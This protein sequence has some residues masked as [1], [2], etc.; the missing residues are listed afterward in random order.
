MNYYSNTPQA[1]GFTPQQTRAAFNQQLA[2]AQASAD[3]RYNMKP[4][5]RAGWSRGGAQNAMAGISSAQNLADGI[6]RAYAG[7]LQD[8]QANAGIGLGNRQS[9]EQAGLSMN[10]LQQQ[11][12]YQAALDAL[13]R[14]QNAMN[15]NQGLLGGLLGQGGASGLNSFLGF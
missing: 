13:Q 3:P 5:D 11:M 9:S 4:M 8:A 1:Q 6:A 14:Q 15:F 12:N 10:A 2:E 7:Q